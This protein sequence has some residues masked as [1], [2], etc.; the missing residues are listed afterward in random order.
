MDL[1]EG[2]IPELFKAGIPGSKAPCTT[3]Q[4]YLHP[5]AIVEAGNGRP[6]FC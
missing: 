3:R 6:G 1:D 2:R 4:Q 5:Q